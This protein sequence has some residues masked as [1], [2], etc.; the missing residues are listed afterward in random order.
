MKVDAERR[1]LWVCSTV[2]PQM[3]GFRKEDEG[4]SSVLKFNLKTGELVKRYDLL[5]KPQPHWLGDLALNSRGDVFITDSQAPGAVYVIF[6][7]KDE[8][9][10]FIPV[11]PFRSP[12]GLDFSEDERHLFVA[13]YSIGILKFDVATRQQTQ[14]AAPENLAWVGIDG[15][16][17]YK[18]SLIAIQNGIRPHRVARFFLSKNHDRIE[19]AEIIEANNPMFNEPTLGALVQDTFFYVANSQWGSFNKD[20]TIFPLEKLQEPIVMKTKL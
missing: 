11:G 19:H 7:Q 6:Q 16:Y 1:T 10:L 20:G 2:T 8:L 18:N 13:D 17:F 12:Q 9:E 3:V 5:N 15:L 4:L 14:L